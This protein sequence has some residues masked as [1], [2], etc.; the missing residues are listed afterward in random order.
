MLLKFAL[1]DF[2]DDREFKNLSEITVKAYMLSLHEF[3]SFCSE[4][5]I[6]DVSEV[7]SV[8]IKSY[9]V[10]CQ[11]N[12]KNNPTTRNS[13][14]HHLKIFF[15]YL[16]KN[17][18]ITEKSNPAKK[19]EYA[20][21][22]IKIEVFN[23]NHIK[24]MLG[25]YRRIKYRDKSLFVYRDYAMILVL[26]GTGIRLG[27][28]CNLKWTDVDLTNGTLIV[29][30]KKRQQSS[31]PITEKLIKELAEY[32]VFCQRAF[33]EL[34]EFIFINRDG[35]RLTPN[36]VKCV[37][38]R[39]KEIMNF[40]D[41][42]LSAH[43]FRHTFAH[44]MLQNGS[45]VFTLQKMLRHSNLKMTE[46]YLALWGTALKEQNDKFNPLNSLEI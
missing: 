25:Y 37:F 20:K 16:E 39:L 14:L 24:Q 8:T 45:D 1:K 6:I 18:M 38:K 35:K 31:V 12:R 4:R 32:K 7:T 46:K 44:R 43:T 19:L 26:I 40:K 10:H 3:Q 9:L 17:E 29:F 28:L 13:K 27:E 23:D 33:N 22:E 15:N 34:P 36:A 2:Q 41:V 42:R 11:K 5:E 30:G 21:E